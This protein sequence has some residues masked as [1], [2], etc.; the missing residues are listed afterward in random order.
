MA[1]I[2]AGQLMTFA[3]QEALAQTFRLTQGPAA[4]SAYLALLTN[5]ASGSLDNTFTTMAAVTEYMGGPANGYARLVFGPTTP[6][7]ASPSVIKNT[8]TLT[9]GP[10]TTAPGT[11]VN[12]GMLTDATGSGTGTTAK[13]ICAFLLANPRTPLL[14]DSL[15]GA[16]NAFTCTV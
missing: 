8:G 16:A 12:W 2:S 5:P 6:T 9:F 1:T 4:S 3:E 13:L 7:A 15:V 10:T 14:G 11:T